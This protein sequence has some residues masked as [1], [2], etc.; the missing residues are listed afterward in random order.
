MKW[1]F[2]DERI[3]VKFQ[4]SALLNILTMTNNVKVKWKIVGSNLFNEKENIIDNITIG[5]SRWDFSLNCEILF[6]INVCSH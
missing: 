2:S 1:L 5:I 6:C 4:C 3:V